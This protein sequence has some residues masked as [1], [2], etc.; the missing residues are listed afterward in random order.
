[1]QP[2]ENGKNPNFEFRTQFPPPPATPAPKSFFLLVITQC[3]KFSSYAIRRKTNEPNM[4]KKLIL[5]RKYFFA[6]FTSNTCY[7][8]LEAIIVYN[9]KEN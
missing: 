7:T 5:G 4:K 2:W 1:M 6:S 9:F 8:L 3:S